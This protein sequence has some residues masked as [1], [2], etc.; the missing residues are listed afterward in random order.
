MMVLLAL[1]GRAWADPSVGVVVTGDTSVQPIAE[2]AVNAWLAAH[3]FTVE[4]KALNKDGINTLSNCL[5]L[6]DMSCAHGVVE[7]RSSVETLVVLVATTSGKKSKDVQ[8]SAYW[9]SKYSDVVSLQRT[10]RGCAGA[11]LPPVVDAVMT[12]LSKM[13]PAMTGKLD[14]KSTPP[15]LIATVDGE[16]VGVTPLV[17]DVPPGP[18]DVSIIRDGKVIDKRSVTVTAGQTEPIEVT[19][20]ALPPPPPVLP[21]TVTVNRSRAVPAVILGVG[22]ATAGA[23]IAMYI[24]GGPTGKSFYYTDYRTPGIGVMAGGGV[25]AIVGTILLFRAGSTEVPVVSITHDSTLVGWSGRF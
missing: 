15:G 11:G 19:A 16:T 7:K 14:I 10:C 17:H 18:H 1:A 6:A 5:A 3:K 24:E 25:L 4:P 12:D 13:V 22:L 8:L 21:K 23:G 20:P 9:M 2:K